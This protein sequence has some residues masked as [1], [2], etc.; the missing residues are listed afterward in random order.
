MTLSA[1]W[2][3]VIITAIAAISGLIF[4]LG[5]RETKEAVQ[6]SAVTDL[7]K[8]LNDLE[9]KLEILSKSVDSD[10][11]TLKEDHVLTRIQIAEITVGVKSIGKEVSAIH[12]VITSKP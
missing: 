6:A 10:I 11:D 12:R 7:K 9:S 5:K 2:V 8:R 3:A 1:E 4:K